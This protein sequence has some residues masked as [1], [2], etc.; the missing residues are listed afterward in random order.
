MSLRAIVF[1]MALLG[2]AATGAS[3]TD[4]AFVWR[5]VSLLGGNEREHMYLVSRH[6]S[7]TGSDRTDSIFVYER[8]NADPHWQQ[9]SL[10]RATLRHGPTDPDTS[11]T[12]AFVANF[13]LASFLVDHNCHPPF[14]MSWPESVAVDAKGMYCHSRGARS[15]FLTHDELLTWLDYDLANLDSK[16]ADLRAVD[17]Y[18]TTAREEDGALTDFIIVRA[19]DA[20][21]AGQYEAIVPVADATLQMAAQ[22]VKHKVPASKKRA[23]HK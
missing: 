6:G 2:A 5:T 16:G 3:A 22:E 9:R 18:R 12:E 11:V 4:E 17:L 14:F 15:Y 1:A 21:D 23:A 8:S 20:S 7:R 19:G 13:D 10:I